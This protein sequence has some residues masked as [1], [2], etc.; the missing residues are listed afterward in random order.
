MNAA[1]TSGKFVVQRRGR[2]SL[3]RA[4]APT[5][6]RPAGSSSWVPPVTARPRW[7]AALPAPDEVRPPPDAVGADPPGADED[8]VEEDPVE[9]DPV[10]EPPA[11]PTTEEPVVDP[12]VVDELVGG[13]EEVVGDVVGG[14][15]VEGDVGIEVVVDDADG[16]AAGRLLPPWVARAATLAIS[17]PAM[18]R[19]A[20]RIE[21]RPTIDT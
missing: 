4:S 6:A 8:P 5:R 3:R 7:P 20:A 19:A 14:V 11:D 10:D 9:E 16:A 2:R 17:S 1:G 18:A 21:R 13:A 12:P 15:V